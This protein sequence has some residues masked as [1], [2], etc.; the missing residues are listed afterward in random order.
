MPFK[1]N[2]TITVY[3]P[4]QDI[5]FTLDIDIRRTYSEGNLIWQG[6]VTFNDNDFRIVPNNSL[7]TQRTDS[8]GLMDYYTY[9]ELKTDITVITH[10]V[11][12]TIIYECHVWSSDLIP[13]GTYY[14]NATS[15]ID[16]MNLYLD[17]PGEKLQYF[18]IE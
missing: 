6:T 4:I 12:G 14:G 7:K 15:S 2:D 11:N 9:P 5:S 3:S 1:I 18:L 16:A 10:N 13:A 17:I 8:F